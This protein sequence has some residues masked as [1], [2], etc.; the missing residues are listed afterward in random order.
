M[1]KLPQLL[2]YGL[3]SL[4]TIILHRQ[5]HWLPSHTTWVA[6]LGPFQGPCKSSP[7]W[8]SFPAPITAVRPLVACIC[9]ATYFWGLLPQ[10]FR[11]GVV[12]AG[13]CHQHL[14]CS[15]R[16]PLWHINFLFLYSLFYISFLRN[17]SLHRG[18]ALTLTVQRHFVIFKFSMFIYLFRY[19]VQT[20]KLSAGNAGACCVW[21][22]STA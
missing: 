10:C 21:L 16:A 18:P 7:L 14:P 20:N 8:D 4:D 11:R 5:G 3:S 1:D 12:P 9:R 13:I 17:K 2:L 15:E 6:P 19:I 22:Y